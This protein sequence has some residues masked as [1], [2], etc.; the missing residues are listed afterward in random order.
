MLLCLG[1]GLA[2]AAAADAGPEASLR[3]KYVELQTRLSDNQFDRPIQL[4]SI[5]TSDG[6]LGDA[7]ALVGHPF[8]TVAE[9]LHR[10]EHW[11]DI[12]NLH[13]NTKFCRPSRAG[14]GSILD[15]VVGRKHDQPLAEAFDLEFAHRVSAQRRSYLQVRLSADEGPLGTRDY[16]IL[17]EAV[18]LPPGQTFIHLSYAYAYGFA[19]ALAVRSYFATIGSQKMGFTVVGVGS[20][21]Q[22]RYVGGVRG[23]V[24]RNTMRY[25]IA[26]EAFLGA[27]S[28]PPHA[29]FEKRIHDWFAAVERYPRQLHDMEQSEYLDMKRKENSRQRSLQSR[30][31]HVRS[32]L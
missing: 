12:L 22:P 7:Y 11:C 30:T 21:G 20:D 6:M 24:E 8:A 17:L 4:D 28:A 31:A 14:Q 32:N 5:E 25:M 15:L 27:L 18:A 1:L 29:R 26:I 13:P 9:A 23:A 10:P 3:D 2:R 19:G 16:R